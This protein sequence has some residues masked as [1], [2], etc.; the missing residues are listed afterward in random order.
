VTSVRRFAPDALAA[1]FGVSAVLHL[2]RP[3]AYAVLIPRFL[4]APGAIIAASGI[5]ELVCA[6]ALFRRVRWAGPASAALLIAVFPGNVW[7]A[8]S[9][10][11]DPSASPWL[12]AGSWLRLPLQIPLVW[13]ALQTR[14][15]AA[16]RP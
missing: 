4:P 6:A 13:I 5:A 16:T 14:P 11:V 2:V 12:V 9:S 1:L 15:R 10:A 3:S 8:L 7:I